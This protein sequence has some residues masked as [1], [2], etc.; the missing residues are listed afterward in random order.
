LSLTL[1]TADE[2]P[3]KPAFRCTCGSGLGAQVGLALYPTPLK[4]IALAALPAH[5]RRRLI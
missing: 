4:S 1:H 2:F 5:N 3:C